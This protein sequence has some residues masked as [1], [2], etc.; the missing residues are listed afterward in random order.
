MGMVRVIGVNGV[1]LVVRV[2]GLGLKLGLCD[3]TGELMITIQLGNLQR[4]TRPSYIDV[5]PGR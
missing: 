4:E 2:L 3:E 1:F 5:K